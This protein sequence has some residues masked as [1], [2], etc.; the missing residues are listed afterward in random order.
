MFNETTI[1]ISDINAGTFVI[2]NSTAA[3]GT[4]VITYVV[5][6]STLTN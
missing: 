3:V 2:T 4:T 6:D 5:E 1:S